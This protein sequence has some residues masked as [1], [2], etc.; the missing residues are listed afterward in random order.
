MQ[1]TQIREASESA[2]QIEA[3][4]AS[5]LLVET[6]SFQALGAALAEPTVVDM[7]AMLGSMAVESEC[8]TCPLPITLLGLT[9]S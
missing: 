1:I 3:R 8:R 9:H 7:Q 5:Q 2:Y 4:C 6:L